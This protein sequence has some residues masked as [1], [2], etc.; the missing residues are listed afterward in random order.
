M[1]LTRDLFAIAK[2]LYLLEDANRLEHNVVQLVRNQL[3][4]FICCY[5]H[6]ECSD[7]QNCS[8]SHSPHSIQ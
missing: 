6:H 2:F 5:I 7:G 8:S 3:Q 1:Q 4:A